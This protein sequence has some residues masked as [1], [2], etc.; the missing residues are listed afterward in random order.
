MIDLH[1]HVVL[2]ATL[3][4][5]GPL[6]PELDDG[7]PATGRLPCFRV[8]GYELVGFPDGRKRIDMGHGFAA[9]LASQAELNKRLEQL[10]SMKGRR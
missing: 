3:G 9:L 5:A 6:G 2:E 10:E 4:A 7:A 8:G 1:A